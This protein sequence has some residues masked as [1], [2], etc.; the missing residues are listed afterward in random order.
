MQLLAMNLASYRSKVKGN[1][2]ETF[3]KGKTEGKVGVGWGE[4][5]FDE[6]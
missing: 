2:G 4:G 6:L 1:K 5:R 3:R